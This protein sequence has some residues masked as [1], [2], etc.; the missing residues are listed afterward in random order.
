MIA[1][2]LALTVMIIAHLDLAVVP[3]IVAAETTVVLGITEV[4]APVT[5]ILIIL[6]EARIRKVEEEVVVLAD[7][8]EAESDMSK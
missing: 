8:A 3:G 2:L 1:Q 7:E 5:E 4:P 6:G